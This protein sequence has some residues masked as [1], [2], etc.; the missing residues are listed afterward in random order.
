MGPWDWF[1]EQAA[2]LGVPVTDAQRQLF[3]RYHALLVK[4]NETTNLTRI[5]DER[6]A[7]V[8]HYLDSLLFLRMVPADWHEKPLRF[9]DV[10]TG[11]GIPGI[12]LLIMRPHWTG[13]LLDSVGKKVAFM[14]QVADE[15]GL[16]GARPLH[17]RAED[18]GQDPAYRE[19]CEL[20][21]A[22]AVAA[23]PELLELTLPFVKPKGLLIVSKGAKGPEE[24]ASAA[25]ALK[26]LNS[27]LIRQE[28]AQL[29]DEAGERHLY[30]IEKASKLSK[31]YPRKA[32]IPHRKPLC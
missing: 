30:V 12:P 2:A 29:P 17:G 4:T 14:Q 15:L 3:E 31:T 13:F 20:G 9:S 22:R 11:P 25:K 7:V 32:G 10:G 24:L 18:F 1:Q 27:E 23:L 28:T 19:T 21:F 26:L 16:S 6:D 5:V 8:K